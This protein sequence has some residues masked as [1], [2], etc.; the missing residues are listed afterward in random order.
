MMVHGF[1][2][3]TQAI[4]ADGYFV[5]CIV[6]ST[7]AIFFPGTIQ[8]RDVKQAGASYE[9]EYGGNAMAAT[10]TRG[11]IDIRFHESFSDESVTRIFR[12]LLKSPDLNWAIDFTV[13]Y[14]GRTL[15]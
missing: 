1:D 12:E 9:D 14:Q 13:R 8:H 6:N 7:T 3:I 10:I 15:F 4:E 2:S 11:M 5:K